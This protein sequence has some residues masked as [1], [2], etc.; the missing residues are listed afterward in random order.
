MTAATGG[1]AFLLGKKIVALALLLFGIIAL[2]SGFV[3]NSVPLIGGGI[4]LLIAS[5]VL[6]AVQIARRNRT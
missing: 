2:S 6:L 1:S 3:Y 5:L 4:V